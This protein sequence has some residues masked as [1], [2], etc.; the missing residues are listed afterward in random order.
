MLGHTGGNDGPQTCPKPA[1]QDAPIE[2][3]YCLYLQRNNVGYYYKMYII[4]KS[5][6]KWM[7]VITQEHTYMLNALPD[8]WLGH[9]AK[10]V[11]GWE[12]TMWWTSLTPS[13]TYWARRQLSVAGVLPLGRRYLNDSMLHPHIHVI[14]RDTCSLSS[15]NE[16]QTQPLT[17]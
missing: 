6:S 3:C 16:I 5:H 9:V 10:N 2:C 1:S 11:L 14:T 8:R 7:A 12:V 13:L 17:T 4:Y 15:S